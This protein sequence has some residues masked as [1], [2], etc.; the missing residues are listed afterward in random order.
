MWPGPQSLLPSVENREEEEQLRA[1]DTGVCSEGL[2]ASGWPSI[3]LPAS[4]NRSGG[5]PVP[6]GP[7][8][9]WVVEV[10]PFSVVAEQLI[11]RERGSEN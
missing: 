4:P 11:L 9:S 7:G 8:D 2:D 10:V 3:V 5:S 1:W 6:Q